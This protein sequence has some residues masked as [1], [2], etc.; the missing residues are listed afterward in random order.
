MLAGFFHNNIIPLSA[1]GH[2]K[3]VRWR[4]VTHAGI[5]GF[6]RLIVYMKCSANNKASTV[7]SLFQEAVERYGLP[8]RVRSDQG[9]ENYAVAR[10][11]LRS[12]GTGRSS[13][14]TGSSVHNQRIERLWRDMHRCVT[15]LYYR[16]FYFL[17]QQGILDPLNET[18]LF[19]LHYVYLA[20]VNRALKIFEEGWNDHG[21]RTA[22]HNSPRQL[23]VQ[24]CLRLQL[25][26]LT[27]MDIFEQVGESYGIDPDEITPSG[28]EV[29]GVNVPELRIHISPDDFTDLQH[30]FNPLSSSDNYGIEIYEGVIAFLRR[31]NMLRSDS[32]SN[33]ETDN[34]ICC[35]A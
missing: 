8:S 19:A 5:D 10:Y 15:V 3:L 14:I 16:L 6:S 11:M 28:T 29:E 27:A 31:R 17:E 26:G 4:F 32:K 7:L 2:H 21:I 1:D 13:M 12:R 35:E 20:R 22:E 24:G 25:S 30:Q 23:F 9:T 34:I 18:H 33:Y